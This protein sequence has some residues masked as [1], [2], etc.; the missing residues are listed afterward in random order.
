MARDRSNAHS[1]GIA[2]GAA[3]TIGGVNVDP[4]HGSESAGFR[5]THFEGNSIKSTKARLFEAI[6]VTAVVL[7][8]IFDAYQINESNRIAKGTTSCELSR[9]CMAMNRLY[10]NNPEMLGLRVE[11]ENK[12]FTPIDP[13]ER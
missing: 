4:A 9:N 10:V 1:R 2:A 13:L 6:G 5:S 11:L 12:N 8:L 3:P 7:S